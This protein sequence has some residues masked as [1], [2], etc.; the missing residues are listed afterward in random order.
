MTLTDCPRCGAKPGEWH[1]RG[2]DI[3]QCPYCGGQAVGCDSDADPIPLDD[4][5][6]WTGQW[7]GEAEAITCNWYCKRTPA[8][9]RTCRPDDP[10]GVPD[11]NRVRKEMVW[12][13]NGKRFVPARNTRREL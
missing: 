4:R 6:R 12:D 9:W 11:L 7:P 3:E 13:R 1:R 5:L 2:C 8:G 10:D